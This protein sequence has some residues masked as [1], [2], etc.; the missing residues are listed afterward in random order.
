M[1]ELKPSRIELRPEDKEEV[2]TIFLGRWYYKYSFLFLLRYYD[3]SFPS[4]SSLF[5]TRRS[6]RSERPSKQ[7]HLN[8]FGNNKDLPPK[9]LPQRSG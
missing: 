5:S 3:V 6:R 7:L 9:N 8:L 2:R 4:Y 1:L